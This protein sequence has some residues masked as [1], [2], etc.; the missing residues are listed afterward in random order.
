MRHAVLVAF[1]LL[2]LILPVP[3]G[4]QVLAGGIAGWIRDGDR[5]PVS[6]A[7]ITLS[8]NG[9]QVRSDS[10]GRFVIANVAPG[11]YALAVMFPDGSTG[12]APAIA[13][14]EDETTAVE[15]E[16]ASPGGPLGI[17][18][19]PGDGRA[20]S[21][22]RV[23]PRDALRAPSVDHLD[24]ALLLLPGVAEPT[25][26]DVP[27]LR[28]G[29]D[30]AAVWL[31]GVPLR[32]GRGRAFGLGLAPNA[33][34]QLAVRTGPM[35]A[36]FGDAQSGIISLITRSGGPGV[37]G[38]LSYETDNLFASGVSLGLNRFEGTVG[39]T[40]ADRIAFFLG[41][42]L[43]G[44]AAAPAGAGVSDV[45]AFVPAGLDTVV[46]ETVEPGVTSQVEIPRFVQYTGDCE[47]ADNAGASCH[48]R[49]LPYDWTTELSVSG[50]VE[51]RYAERSALAL[52][53]LSHVAQDR[54]WAG[55]L[56][57]NP[58][59][60]FGSRSSGLAW[61]LSWTQ[62]VG[63]TGPTL[64]AAVSRQ[65]A[66]AVAG[67]LDAAWAGTHQS[68][69]AGIVV[70]P[71][72]LVVDFDRFSADTGVNAV[73]RLE[74]DDDWERLVSNVVTN[75]GTRVPYLDREDL[76]LSQPYRMNPWAAATGFPTAGVD[77]P[78][79]LA[80]E[81]H[82]IG[83]GTVTWA[84]G[85]GLRLRAGADH[86]RSRVN[87]LSSD[88]IRQSFMTVYSEDP[89]Q[90]G[91]FAE[92]RIEVGGLAVDA[93]L[94]WDW[95]DP[96]TSFPVTPGRIFTHPN[97]DPTDPYDPA[98]SVFAPAESRSALS[99]R[100]RAVFTI[101]PGTTV[102][103]GYAQHAR[104][105]DLAV[106]FDGQNRDLAF[107]NTNTLL[108][109]PLD[110][111]RSRQVEIGVRQRL[112]SRLG[113]DLAAYRVDKVSDVAVQIQAFFDPVTLGDLN[114][115]VPA[116]ADTGSVTGL[117]A[118]LMGRPARW[119]D[120]FASYSLADGRSTLSGVF[121]RKHT[122]AGWLAARWPEGR[123]ADSWV[124]RIL[125]DG[126]AHV[127]FRLSSGLPYLPL[128]NAGLGIVAPPLRFIDAVSDERLET[129]TV[130]E[131]DLRVARAFRA[132]GLRWSVFAD[133][134]N[135]LGWRNTYRLFA[136]TGGLE[137]PLHREL[138]LGDE[139]TRL[140]FEAGARWTQITRDGQA[141]FAADLTGDCN[142]WNNGPVNCVLLRRAEARWGN[143]DGF[144]DE[145][146]IRTALD[147]MYDLFFGPW[148]L[149]GP[150]RHLRVGVEIRF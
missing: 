76:R 124:A 68:P 56:A 121:N 25:Q 46:V 23:L 117:E 31:D 109:G 150:P 83:R 90:W 15:L 89:V 8:G 73:T 6:G 22:V 141:V 44:R 48:G 74:S 125:R 53:G 132:A 112:G 65:S 131:L 96:G 87:L 133:A 111:E 26:G 78:V 51:W 79:G 81:R 5:A 3:I 134:R 69:T 93:G 105:P 19:I 58:D 148:T 38:D 63:G 43:A 101:L 149:Q 88:L 123:P 14:V 119:L 98:D 34:E 114:L 129:P 20:A 144:Y 140:M 35:S 7:R 72:E 118:G 95:F 28:G 143:G 12:E 108:S 52:T 97:F 64:Q 135:L 107:S 61:V 103:A 40:L 70:S 42:T 66:R 67:P 147:A 75:T 24:D 2:S 54:F 13:V 85:R 113:V 59:T 137:N 11:T 39:G 126:E 120:L 4:A 50:K 77:V 116:N 1:L 41:G 138:V 139:I 21:T 94:R 49:Q 60:H 146:E 127:R 33:I 145:Q 106:M 92:G 86:A 9:R 45:L 32:T 57:F 115:L 10:D 104:H 27:M 130:K 47:A 62:A 100:V 17:R 80:S 110:W 84:F 55:P 18:T 91:L 136:E 71:I 99:P 128:S 122:V 30:E 36:T 82:W 16:A 102:R 37:R 142:T 29:L